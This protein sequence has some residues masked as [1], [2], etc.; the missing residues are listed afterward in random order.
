MKTDNGPEL[1]AQVRVWS[2]ART[3]KGL[4]V[5]RTGKPGDIVWLPR[6]M[7]L[8]EHHPEIDFPEVMDI[9]VP[10]WLAVRSNLIPPSAVTGW[11]QE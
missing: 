9:V 7:V 1:L 11:G 2:I 6:G 3:P 8:A 5:S 10:N 4:G